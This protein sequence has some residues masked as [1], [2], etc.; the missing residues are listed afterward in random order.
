MTESVI[1]EGPLPSAGVVPLLQAVGIG[2]QTSAVRLFDG[3]SLLGELVLRSGKVLQAEFGTSRGAEALARM[4]GQRGGTFTVST[5]SMPQ[6]PE[7]LGDLRTMLQ[8]VG[9]PAEVTLLRD[10]PARAPKSSTGVQEMPPLP[11]AATATA[12]TLVSGAPPRPPPV[13]KA[14]SVAPPRAHAPSSVALPRGPT[15][16]IPIHRA[17]VRAAIQAERTCPVIAIASSKGGV[18]KTTIALNSAVAL[19]R[20]G[21]RVILIDGDPNGGVSAAVNA[22]A[23]RA[24][25]VFDVLCGAARINDALITTR[26]NGL[27]VLP[28]GGSELSVEQIENAQT[29][30]SGWQILMPQIARDADIVIIDTP[31]GAFGPTR[32]LA[33]CATHVLGVLQAEPLAM[34]VADQLGRALGSIAN[35]PKV[36]GFVIN[37]FDSRSAASASVLQEACRTFPA[38]HV[39]ETPIP[40]TAVINEASL[41][42]LV[43]AQADLATAPAIAWA[44]EQF[45]AEVLS[46]LEVSRAPAVLDDTPLF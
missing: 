25:G 22:Q 17:A 14:E 29:H 45:A 1:L 41:R 40:R 7:P 16:A 21:M 20:R 10:L 38:G 26:M 23:R 4:I 46:R 3:A 19:A 28:A 33:S 43:P 15:P 5:L 6:L 36:L 44:F 13:P 18:G 30:A 37:M 34:R 32:V 2:R 35:A 42:G 27:R 12:P 39:F 9:G 31:A 8:D 11:D 24:T